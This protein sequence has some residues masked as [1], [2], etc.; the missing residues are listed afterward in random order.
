MLTVT[1]RKRLEDRRDIAVRDLAELAEQVES[2][3]ID[4]DTAAGLRANYQ[5]ELDD[6]AA[7]LD[8]LPPEVAPPSSP[9]EARTPDAGAPPPR[10]TRRA[11]IGSVLVIAALSVAIFLAAGDIDPE[12]ATTDPAAA[13][14]L[15]VDPNS[16]TNEQLEAV[17]A[18]NPDI[19]AMRLALADRYFDEEDYGPAL[20]HYLFV[21]ENNPTP[22]EEGR[23][24][25]RIGWM[26]YI[27]G[28][29]ETAERY[30]QTSLTADP[31]NAETKL[32]LG[33]V[34]LYGL[35]DAEAAIPWLEEVA[36]APNVPPG[37]LA[38]VETALDDARSG[39]G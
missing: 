21:V 7:R 22:A 26:A 15:P 4:D 14:E 18:Q 28:Q 3:E 16:V 32:F 35:E 34:L 33:F 2:G 24:L 19:N 29:P 36:Q 12:P 31:T 27:T 8:A 38:Q 11:V 1:D 37:I 25:S 30:L 13:G 6:V 10:S 39:G 17:V 9:G 23:A 5:A 20:D